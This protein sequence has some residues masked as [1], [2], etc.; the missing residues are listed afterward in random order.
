MANVQTVKEPHPREEGGTHS[1][2]SPS[3]NQNHIPTPEA[4]REQLERL[5]ASPHFASS[6]RCQML[7]RYV[8]EQTIRGNAESLKERNLGI[9]VFKR[10]VD[11][12]TNANPVVR[13]AASEVRKKLAQY[14]F[15]SDSQWQIR[16]EIP[17]RHL[18]AGVLDA[19]LGIG[20]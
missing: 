11:Y 1:V 18:C 5:L 10:D 2:G 16:I 3:A 13:V 17:R 15:E 7:L 6:P 9:E 19:Q 4:A 12:D 14:Y 20:G 8:V